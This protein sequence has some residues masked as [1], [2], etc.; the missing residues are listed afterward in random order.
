MSIAHGIRRA[1]V[2]GAGQMGTSWI[3]HVLRLTL[4]LPRARSGDCLRICGAREGPGA[5]ARPVFRASQV[6]TGPLRQDPVEGRLE[7]QADFG[8]GE[9]GSG[10]CHGG[11]RPE[12]LQGCG[13]S[14]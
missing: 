5:A 13:H 12:G 14:D 9:G 10:S 11:R 2:I 8:G 6:W 3:A 7:G 1:G 4:T